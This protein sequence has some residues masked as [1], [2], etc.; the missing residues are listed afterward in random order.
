MPKHRKAAPSR[1]S[2]KPDSA[3]PPNGW[4][5]SANR[6]ASPG[7]SVV[8]FGGQDLGQKSVGRGRGQPRPREI[9]DTIASLRRLLG[10]RADGQRGRAPIMAPRS[11]FRYRLL[12]ESRRRGTPRARRRR[13]HPHLR[14][15]RSAADRRCRWV[16]RAPTTPLAQSLVTARR[17]A[18]TLHSHGV[19]GGVED[20]GRNG[21]PLDRADTRR[22][23]RRAVVR[24]ISP[25]AASAKS[26]R[27]GRIAPVRSNT[28]PTSS[29]RSVHFST[30]STMRGSPSWHM[31]AQGRDMRPQ[32]LGHV[33]VE[34]VVGEEVLRARGEDRDLRIQ[35]RRVERRDPVSLARR[36]PP[37]EPMPE[38]QPPQGVQRSRKHID[39]GQVDGVRLIGWRHDRPRM[40]PHGARPRRA[41]ATASPPWPGR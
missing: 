5:R 39:A 37:P 35:Q 24:P 21:G 40:R 34:G 15:G 2:T 8:G 28:M 11:R 14:R 6:C 23:S 9:P 16:T 3:P 7:V 25:P 33:G 4:R 27:R 31:G 18:S 30:S 32:H 10:V 13:A 29:A 26:S 22:N 1:S 12:I 17:P 38:R 36:P 41:P 19:L 20:S